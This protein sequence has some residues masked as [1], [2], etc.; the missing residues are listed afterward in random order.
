MT[1]I[2]RDASDFVSPAEWAL[3]GE[4]HNLLSLH[5]PGHIFAVNADLKG[6]VVIIQLAYPD[7]GKHS[8]SLKDMLSQWGY[9]IRIAEM[10]TPDERRRLV[11]NGGG[12]LLERY[13]LP[14]SK[15]TIDTID[16]AA[17][18]GLDKTG[19]PDYQP[20]PPLLVDQHG[21]PLMLRN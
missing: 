3:A 9:V 2:Q 4:V 15:A 12:E 11:I 1:L 16:R 8:G 20:K 17:E 14:R 7:R 5:Y 19:S 21:R 13:R 10:D 6:G 18:H